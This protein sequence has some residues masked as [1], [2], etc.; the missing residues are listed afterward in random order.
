LAQIVGAADGRSNEFREPLMNRWIGAALIVALGA[1]V[2]LADSDPIKAR[3]E[4]MKANGAAT[5]T[6]VGMLKGA[7]FDLAAAQTALK[8]Y[9]AAAAKAPELFPDSSKTGDTNALPAIWQNKADFDA[10]F[11]TFGD[12]VAAAESKITDEAS[13]KANI[14]PVLK[15][16]GGCHQTYRASLN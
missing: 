8:T 10:R 12:D 13:F 2:A 11:K 3:R 9:A 6:V 14:T 4:L 15:N 5:K 7:P 16:C 1:S